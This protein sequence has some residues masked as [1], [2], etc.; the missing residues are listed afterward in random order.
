MDLKE[1]HEL[2]LQ[3]PGA[4]TRARATQRRVAIH[5][6]EAALHSVQELP[7]IGCLEAL[8]VV[9]KVRQE[10]S[11]GGGIG[12]VVVTH[13]ML[14]KEL[15]LDGAELRH[16]YVRALDIA[17]LVKVIG[18]V[19][20]HVQSPFGIEK[21]PSRPSSSLTKEQVSHK[22]SLIIYFLD[23][24]GQINASECKLEMSQRQLLDSFK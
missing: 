4:V 9:R 12:L 16:E 11:V 22:H 13:G 7:G 1:V 21:A 3:A 20:A 10:P 14:E 24:S 15:P 18:F 17:D 23:T 2:I 19:R 5:L 8:G 6:N